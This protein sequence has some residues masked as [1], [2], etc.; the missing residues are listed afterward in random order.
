MSVM[1][2]TKFELVVTLAK[3]HGIEV[4]PNALAAADKGI[5]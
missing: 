4:S 3:A 1:Q 2:P 5:Q